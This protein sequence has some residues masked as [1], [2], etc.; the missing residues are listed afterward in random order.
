MKLSLRYL[1]MLGLMLV[2]A[3]LAAALRPTIFLADER[4]SID[5]K[6][7]VPRKFGD[8]HELPGGV[9]QIIDPQ[10][11][12]LINKI[13][14]ETL[15]RTY[16]NRDGYQIMLSIAYGKNQSDGLQL[17]KPDVCYPAQGFDL[18]GKQLDTLNLG[19]QEIQITRLMTRL[20]QRSEP[21]IYWTVTGDTITRGG[22]DKKLAEI[23]YSL[24]NRIPDGLL[25]RISSIDPNLQRAYRIQD[26]FAAAL[27]DSMPPVVRIRF[28]GTGNLGIPSPKPNLAKKLEI[29]VE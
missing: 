9:A 8:W 10:A 28:T 5:L 6:T 27:V 26:Q 7:V 23:Q 17:H 3:A 21:L 12:Q 11:L 25:I 2:S 29:H 14:T 13:Y 16:V 15:T 20:Q 4:R 1:L 24:R 18:I 19:D 22:V